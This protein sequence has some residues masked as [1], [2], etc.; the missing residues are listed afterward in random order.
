MNGDVY[1]DTHFHCKISGHNISLKIYNYRRRENTSEASTIKRVRKLYVFGESIVGRWAFWNI[2]NIKQRGQKYPL[3]PSSD[4]DT[5]CKVTYK[6][7][8]ITRLEDELFWVVLPILNW[9]G[10]RSFIWRAQ[11]DGRFSPV[12]CLKITLMPEVT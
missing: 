2:Y 3:Y 7:F 6:S 12:S 9:S 8:V 5:E 4:P 11:G 10:G 1:I